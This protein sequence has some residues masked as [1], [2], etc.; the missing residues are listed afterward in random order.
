MIR[1]T[2]PIERRC[3]ADRWT[4]GQTDGR[5]SCYNIVRA[6]KII[7]A[8]LQLFVTF[9]VTSFVVAG[10]SSQ[11]HACLPLHS[12]ARRTIKRRVA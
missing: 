10:V 5:I 7:A 3:V 11:L 9:F 12:T 1:V 4:D 6:V 2:V 8:S